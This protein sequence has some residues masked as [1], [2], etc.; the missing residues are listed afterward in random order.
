MEDDL[1]KRIANL[2][3]RE[4]GINEQTPFED[5]EALWRGVLQWMKEHWAAIAIAVLS[6]VG[7]SLAKLAGGFPALDEPAP[8]WV[9]PVVLTLPFTAIAVYFVVRFVK[10]RR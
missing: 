7:A 6:L 9:G 2:G 1:E 5:P 8:D 3:G 4:P 10:S